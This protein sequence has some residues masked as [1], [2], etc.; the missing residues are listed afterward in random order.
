MMLMKKMKSMID[1]M[2]RTGEIMMGAVVGKKRVK[3][4]RRGSIRAK[5]MNNKKINSKLKFI[6]K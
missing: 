6:L 5:K 2:N 3:G 1:W 4:M